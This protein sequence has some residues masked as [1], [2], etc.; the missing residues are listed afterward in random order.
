MPEKVTL[1][2]TKRSEN[3]GELMYSMDRHYRGQMCSYMCT[4]YSMDRHYRQ[5]CS[6]VYVLCTM[7]SMDRQ[8]RIIGKCAPICVNVQ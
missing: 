2:E 3:L 5:M 8:C 1:F 7:Y 4:M 6:Y